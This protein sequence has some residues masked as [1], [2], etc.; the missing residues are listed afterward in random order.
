MS[1]LEDRL[2]QLERRVRSLET[3]IRQDL[4]LIAAS[5]QTGSPGRGAMRRP[6][7]RAKCWTC[8]NAMVVETWRPDKSGAP[9]GEGEGHYTPHS[10]CRLYAGVVDGVW[11]IPGVSAGFGEVANCYSYQ[12]VPPDG[13]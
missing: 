11:K 5:A 6:P 2:Q 1:N 3:G 12:E 8:S 13:T 4:E 7:S 10:I 9:I